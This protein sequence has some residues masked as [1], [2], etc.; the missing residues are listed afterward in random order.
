MQP[1]TTNNINLNNSNYW[2]NDVT[3]C[4]T[5]ST[6]SSFFLKYFPTDRWHCSSVRFEIWFDVRDGRHTHNESEGDKDHL[7]GMRGTEL[8]VSFK[9]S[10]Q[11]FASV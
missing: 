5:A 1:A 7:P 9:H 10:Q 6:V 3:N 4:V 8:A 11:H 2:N